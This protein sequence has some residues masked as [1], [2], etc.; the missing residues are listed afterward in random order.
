[1]PVH[2]TFDLSQSSPTPAQGKQRLLGTHRELSPGL[3]ETSDL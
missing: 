1:M 2:K 3:E